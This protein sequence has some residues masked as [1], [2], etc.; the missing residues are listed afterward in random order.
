M[1]HLANMDPR[2]SATGV[3]ERASS[4]TNMIA[5]QEKATTAGSLPATMRAAEPT[6]NGGLDGAIYAPPLFLAVLVIILAGTA[7]LRVPLCLVTGPLEWVLAAGFFVLLW[8]WYQ[9]RT[10]RSLGL[11]SLLAILATWLALAVYSARLWPSAGD[12]LCLHPDN[13]SYQAMSDYLD[14]YQRGR[15]DGMPMVDEFG[16]NLEGAR[17]ATAGLV[18]FLEGLPILHDVATA[19]VL[20]LGGLM[21]IHFFSMLALGRALIGR[22]N[23]WMPLLAAFIATAG[24]WLSHAIETGNN[25]NL[26]FVALSPALLALLCQRP[27]GSSIRWPLP[28]AGTLFIA[29]LLYTYPEGVALLALLAAPLAVNF[30]WLDG[31]RKTA[32]ARWTE[33]I[34]MGILGVLL[35]AP[36]LP[37]FVF[38]LRNQIRAGVVATGVRPGEGIFTG[39][40]DSH[41]F[42]GFFA[43]GEELAGSSYQPVN[44]V[45]PVC[46][47]ALLILGVYALGRRQRWFAWV[48]L[49]FTGLI[50]WQSVS[51]HYDY[52]TYKILICSA[53]WIYPAI[54]AGLW[55]IFRRFAWPQPLQIGVVAA[56]LFGIGWEKYEHRIVAPPLTS[57]SRVKA[58][59]D[60]RTIHFVTGQ[61]PVLL[62][63]DE[64]IDH[65]WATYY[66]RDL[67]LATWQQK[68]YLSMPH[69]APYLARGIAPSPVDC[70]F[71]LVSG[72]RPNAL[73]QNSLFS[74]LRRTSLY[75]ADIQN[76]P[77]GIES[78]GG[79]RF[80]WL[81]TQPATFQVIAAQ[82]G[83]YELVAT[84]FGIGPSSPDKA[85]IT[86]EITD[87]EGTHTAEVS[88]GVHGLPLSLASGEN[89]VKLRCLGT[90]QPGPHN[91]DPRELM[92]GMKGPAVS[93]PIPAPAPGQ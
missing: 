46:L 4:L 65:L 20:F 3:D 82:P 66:L 71:M 28:A 72:S 8:R 90:P 70:Q 21:V 83:S 7:S 68:G 78:L 42:P 54:S 51:K 41:R 74:L 60:L 89:A 47:C 19:H 35:T 77:N 50:Y 1:D 24:G 64:P 29:A 57:D 48:A 44:N 26:V 85:R 36:Y 25:D 12:L 75:I 87:A 33:L 30:L 58:W 93:A 15:V 39:L 63:V 6:T 55:W 56:L 31:E 2:P 53:W 37:T 13:W 69:I 27:A 86:V 62:A 49:P 11:L 40:V 91:G 59:T 79:E 16:A 17:F 23:W 10:A 61:A 81:G 32:H 73:W 18:A 67:P 14:H 88:A 5:N 80:L 45:V 43:L 38:F 84:I 76:P 52:G 34:V 22:Q 92:L 9:P